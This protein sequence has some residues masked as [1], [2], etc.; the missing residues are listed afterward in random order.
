[1]KV[2]FTQEHFERMKN[3][4]VEMLLNNE[5]ISDSFVVGSSNVEK[6]LH[7][8]SIFRLVSI[9]RYL[10]KQIEPLKKLNGEANQAK[11]ENLKKK[12]DLISLIISYK[13]YKFESE[14]VSSTK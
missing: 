10:V 8:T 1:M 11:L 6:L 3:L 4:L 9:R 14:E 12:K 5:T 2:N 13:R 7:T